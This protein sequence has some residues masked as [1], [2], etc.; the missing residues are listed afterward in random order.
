M[1]AFALQNAYS[2]TV[3]VLKSESDGEQADFDIDSNASDANLLKQKQKLN[4]LS[5]ERAQ[6][7]LTNATVAA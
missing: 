2:K 1:G 7:D 6:R 4:K 5:S 3:D